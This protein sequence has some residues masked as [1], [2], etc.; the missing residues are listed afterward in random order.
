MIATGVA[1]T[2]N[3][4]VN[5]PANPKIYINDYDVT[6]QYVGSPSVGPGYLVEAYNV[7][8]PVPCNRLVIF[9]QENGFGGDIQN[10]HLFSINN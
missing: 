8:Y 9:G 6:E 2:F 7:N 5:V 1:S 10:L 4:R 3:L